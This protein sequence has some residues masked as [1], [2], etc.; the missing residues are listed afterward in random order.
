M[1]QDVQNYRC[2]IPILKH[3]KQYRRM[4]TLRASE[5]AYFTTKRR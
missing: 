3:A 5:S 4:I 1:K 2:L